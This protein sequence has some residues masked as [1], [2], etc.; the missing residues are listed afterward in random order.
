MAQV[1]P[2]LVAL[3][4]WIVRHRTKIFDLG[5]ILVLIAV[6]CVVAFEID[7]FGSEAGASRAKLDLD[8]NELMG[9]VA[10]VTA[11]L[12]FYTWRRAREHV[13]ENARRLQA[14]REVLNL[15]LHDPLT[16]LPNRR[17]FDEA[18]RRALA[19]VPTA[20]EAHAI[21]LLD[22]NGFKK[23]N[24]VHGHPV[25]DQVLI[26]VGARL[27]RAV[28][29]GDLVARLGGDEFAILAR[30]VSGSEGAAT[31]ALRVIDSLAEPVQTGSLRHAIGAAIG[32][33]LSPQDGDGAEELLRKADV[34]LYRA[35]AERRSAL[36]FFEEAMD[37]RLKERADL[38]RALR[39]DWTGP[40][41]ALQFQPLVGI[42]GAQV[43]GFEASPVWRHAALGL[44]GPDRFGAVAEEAGLLADLTDRLL[45]DACGA[46]TAWPSGVRLSF[47][48]PGA[49]L[50]DSA[51]GLRILAGLAQTGLSPTRLDLEVDEGAL[52][53]DLDA[54]E[55]LLGPLRQAGI[56]V[57]ASHFGT[58]Y[59]DLRNLQKLKLDRIKIDR[60]FIEAMTQ[61]RKAAVMVKALIGIGQGLDLAVI[62]EGVGTP[63]QRAALAAQGCEQAQGPVFGQALDAGEALA[64]VRPSS[65]A[66][67]RA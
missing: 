64:L 34:A 32:I 28:R 9:L 35:K 67:R 26:H 16:G 3:R 66:R 55:A 29:E 45:R 44:I 39:D 51:F 22:L 31:I 65:R 53:R 61:D 49:L 41:F 38:E 13:R 4:N 52:I 48:L 25:G 30:N 47:S 58:G 60:S 17:Q 1:G 21:L 10:V 8:L 54:A 59:S 24:D 2:A 12:L 5:F 11:G 42:D 19:T 57:V 14:E 33:A 6:A 36:R 40:A 56:A 37:A 20:P 27:L 63:E 62:A 50:A 18:F 46:A 7:I 23:V 43:T 15:A